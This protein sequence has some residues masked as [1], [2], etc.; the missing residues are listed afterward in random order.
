M[1]LWDGSELRTHRQTH[2]VILNLCKHTYKQRRVL[3]GPL[4]I[5]KIP[6]HFKASMSL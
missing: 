1:F 2:S 3:I 4:V 5:F 6:L